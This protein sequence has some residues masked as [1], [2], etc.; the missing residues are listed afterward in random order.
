MIFIDSSAL[1][2]LVSANDPRHADALNAWNKALA[3][4]STLITTNYVVTETSALAQGRL[5]F[6]ACAGMHTALLPLVRVH[7]VEAALHAAALSLWMS[8]GR[9]KLSLVDCVSATFMRMARIQTAF[10][11]DRH[12]HEFGFATL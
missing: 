9:R 8:E 2:A 6:K 7:Y 5:G 3:S 12:F 11:Y 4:N 10:A 1:Y